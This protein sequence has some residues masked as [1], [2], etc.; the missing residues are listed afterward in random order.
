MQKSIKDTLLDA[1][2]KEKKILSSFLKNAGLKK[3]PVCGPE[4]GR[5][6]ELIYLLKKPENI[7]E[8]GCGNGFSTY[9]I[10]KHLSLRGTYIGID[11]NRD[12]LRD[13]ESFISGSFQQS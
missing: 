12:R 7:L 4:T 13:G 5:F 6:L 1:Y 11:Q 9:F 10:V 8:I 2:L 3:I